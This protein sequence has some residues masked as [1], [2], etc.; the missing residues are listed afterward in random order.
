MND[1]NMKR[2]SALVKGDNPQAQRQQE[3]QDIGFRVVSNLAEVEIAPNKVVRICEVEKRDRNNQMQPHMELRQI[4]TREGGEIP[5]K[6]KIDLPRNN[7]DAALA[8][9]T[10]AMIATCKELGI[11]IPETE[12]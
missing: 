11:E 3:P 8:Q 1:S 12:E 10:A 7:G 6:D 9:L 5:T 4:I 2:F